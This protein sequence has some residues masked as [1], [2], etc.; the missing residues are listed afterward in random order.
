[1]NNTNH[2]NNKDHMNNLNILNNMDNT[3]NMDSWE[4]TD[5]IAD[6][7]ERED[8]TDAEVRLAMVLSKLDDVA[9]C[10]AQHPVVHPMQL[11]KEECLAF[12]QAEVLLRALCHVRNINLTQAF[13]LGLQNWKDADWRRAQAEY[14]GRISGIF[15]HPGQVIGHA[16]VVDEDHDLG[17]VPGNSI[18]VVKNATPDCIVAMDA[19]SGLITDH[20]GMTCDAAILAREMGIPCI[21]GTG[22]ATSA[23]RQGD[24]V[25]FETTETGYGM[26]TILN[27]MA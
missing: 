21:V 19:I 18:L 24:L 27:R 5:V 12:G 10:I 8:Q 7:M 17:R 15:A 2:M 1:M 9:K 6:L 13:K 25:A 11:R 16:Y 3:G 22:N 26:V 14:S 4:T 23:L 20:G